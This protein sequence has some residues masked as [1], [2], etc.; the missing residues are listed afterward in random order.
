ME[1]EES[2]EEWR[3]SYDSI[4]N[5]VFMKKVLS[6]FK[7]SQLLKPKKSK[8]AFFARWKSELY[9]AWLDNYKSYL[10][11]LLHDDDSITSETSTSKPSI[12]GSFEKI[13]EIIRKI[14]E[15]IQT[16]LED[17]N[18]D[19]EKWLVEEK[20]L[21][22]YK[23]INHTGL[24]NDIADRLNFW[25]SSLFPDIKYNDFWDQMSKLDP[26]LKLNIIETE[27][28]REKNQIES[29]ENDWKN[30]I[31]VLNKQEK[32]HKKKLSDMVAY[33]SYLDKECSE[34]QKCWDDIRKIAE[35]L[36]PN[37]QVVKIDQIIKSRTQ[38]LDKF[39][40]NFGINSSDL[41]YQSDD[42]NN[43]RS[44]NKILFDFSGSRFKLDI[45]LR[46]RKTAIRTI[47]NTLKV[48]KSYLL[49][50]GWNK[51]KHLT[52]IKF[53]SPIATAGDN[54]TPLAPRLKTKPKSSILMNSRRQ[55]EFEQS[56]ALK[57]QKNNFR[58]FFLLLAR[59]V[60]Y[61]YKS[62]LKLLA[63][64]SMAR[65]ILA[66]KNRKIPE[67]KERKQNSGLN[68]LKVIFF[69][70][71]VLGR[72]IIECKKSASLNLW[73]LRSEIA[74]NYDLGKELAK[75]EDKVKVMMFKEKEKSLEF[76]LAYQML[77]TK[78][79]L[80]EKGIELTGDLGKN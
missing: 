21:E 9:L 68:S 46:L 66:S 2:H 24:S 64:H 36:E 62:K 76:K 18:K 59:R 61:L 32:S 31:F 35:S 72:N 38:S 26:S 13:L 74:K 10:A 7:I 44:S 55:V 8:K 30:K 40:E 49:S 65:W 25:K 54:S 29:F 39:Y 77:N 27:L 22:I 78:L 33:H 79:R 63:K 12:L 75:I 23:N 47:F 15:I 41:D 4:S 45:S 60:Y 50:K 19:K 42:E 34:I 73:R 67:R 57:V 28:I 20:L 6:V 17:L 80:I 69:M 53:F 48:K 3:N 5:K 70:S 56:S 43:F 16:S 51:W 37:T 71:V 52:Q 58:K 14:F 1:L 11:S